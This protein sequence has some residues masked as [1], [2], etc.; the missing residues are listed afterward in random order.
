MLF[1]II[2]EHI[3]LLNNPVIWASLVVAVFSYFLLIELCFLQIKDKAWYDRTLQW[4]KCLATILGSLPLL[5]LLGT[6][7]GLLSTFTSMANNNGFD[8]Q[9]IMT[10]GIASAMFTTQ[11]GL[12]LAIPGLLMMAVLNA[13]ITRWEAHNT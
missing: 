7:D 11:L 3:F 9:E 6:I 1:S 8:A 12:V 10:G 2:K 13:K 4:N 5:G